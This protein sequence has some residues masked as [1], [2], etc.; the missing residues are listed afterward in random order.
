MLLLL[1][2]VRKSA[3][4]HPF[5]VTTCERIAF[6]TTEAGPIFH[7]GPL[8]W[9][10]GFWIGSV[11][12]VTNRN[13]YTINHLYHTLSRK[14]KQAKS[15]TVENIVNESTG[16]CNYHATLYFVFVFH[17]SWDQKH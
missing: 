14:K 9:A 17:F 2:S 8:S 11:L 16:F 5:A 12:T 13:L 10:L 15:V 7:T 3:T 6:F 4:H 1:R